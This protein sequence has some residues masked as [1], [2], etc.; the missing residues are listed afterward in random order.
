MEGRCAEAVE[1]KMLPTSK[2]QI[3]PTAVEEQFTLVL[4]I[5]QKELAVS[6]GRIR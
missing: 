4:K 5:Y 3:I 6:S 1:L 2:Q